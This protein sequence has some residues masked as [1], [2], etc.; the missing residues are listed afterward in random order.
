LEEL[1]PIQH[2]YLAALAQD[3]PTIAAASTLVHAFTI[4]LRGR[5]GDELDAW[6]TAATEGP[7]A[8]L[9]SFARGLEKD[10]AAVQAGLT[11]EWSQGQVE[12]QIHRLKFLKRS[13]SGRASFPVLRQ[14]VLRRV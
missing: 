6:I 12:G 8:E 2:T 7:V 13:M 4:M 3:E 9:R 5:H 11:E 14:R 10:K 1:P